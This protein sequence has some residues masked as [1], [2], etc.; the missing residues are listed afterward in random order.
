MIRLTR[1]HQALISTFSTIR[2]LEQSSSSSTSGKDNSQSD[3]TST[4]AVGQDEKNQNKVSITERLRKLSMTD[5]SSV[6]FEDKPISPPKHVDPRLLKLVS[7]KNRLKSFQG[8]YGGNN[9]GYDVSFSPLKYA[10]RV[11]NTQMFNILLLLQDRYNNSNNYSRRYEKQQRSRSFYDDDE[12]EDNYNRRQDG[13]ER[14]LYN[15]NTYGRP[16]PPARYARRE[17]DEFDDDDGD[18]PFDKSNIRSAGADATILADQ[19]Q[20]RRN[21]RPAPAAAVRNEF[22]DEDDYEKTVRNRF[23]NL[24]RGG[25]DD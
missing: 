3:K 7:S 14:R 20:F 21:G 18:E 9:F 23:A 13:N 19:A 12:Y 16:A 1:F 5:I 10:K 11:H 8:G 6:D 4:R 15:R 25:V 24:K 17:F 2:N 22:S